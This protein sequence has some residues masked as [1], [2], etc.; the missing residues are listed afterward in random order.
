MVLLAKRR[1][2]CVVQ[3]WVMRILLGYL[4][5]W[6]IIRLLETTKFE[7]IC[8]LLQWFL[9]VA[10]WTGEHGIFILVIIVD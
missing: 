5:A 1:L 6:V 7:V 2:D 8:H 3:V 10:G 4:R 9:L